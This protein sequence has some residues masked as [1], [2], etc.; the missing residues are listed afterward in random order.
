MFGNRVT[1][2]LAERSST[3]PSPPLSAVPNAQWLDGQGSVSRS[4]VKVWRI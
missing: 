1:G 3:I 2:S 4:G